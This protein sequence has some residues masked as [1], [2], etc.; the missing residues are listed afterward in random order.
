MRS[1]DMILVSV[2]D[3]IIEPADLFKDRLPAAYRDR[4]PRVAT[5][6]NGDERWMIEGK[7]WAGV[8]PAA[9]CGRNRDELGDEP[10]RYVDV[11]KGAFDL[12]ARIDDMNVNGVLASLNFPSMAGFSGEKFTAG[13]DKGL[14]LALIQAY[15]DWH[16]EE[17]AGRY[18]GRMI[19]LA[20]VPLWDVDLAIAELRRMSARGVRIVSFPEN[21]TSF[22]QPSIHW[23][24][25]DRFFAEVV[26]LGM[27][28][29]IHIGTSGP[30][31]APSMESP[32]L[33]GTVLLNIK[34][35]DALTDLLFS[36][37]LTKFPDLRFAMS[38]GCMGWVPFLRERADSAYRNHKYWT[39]ADLA[40]KQPSEI[41]AEQFMFCFHEDDFG[42]SVR[43]Q[44]GIDQI[45]WECDFPHADS[46]WPHSAELLWNSVKN[47]PRD[48]I[49][50]ITHL[51]AMRFLNFDPFKYIDRKDATVGALQAKAAHVSTALLSGGGLK[52]VKTGSS[53]STA[54]V[55]AMFQQGNASL[56]EPVGYL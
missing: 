12:D 47:F 36:P 23:G 27:S 55:L 54:D 32:A 52:P 19:P 33:V 22:G 16:V 15:N 4:T 6:A 56:G 30:L 18:P 38:E 9:V 42:L 24:H 39:H 48:E 7:A 28:V 31:D 45:A 46:T 44:V 13:Q 21:P 2:D 41:L 20:M 8:G 1:E 26:D 11:R 10:T 5:F 3:H 17:W 51:N 25:W 35:A 49:D 14:M 34:I 53:M 37:L 40:G 43:H 50:R 29:A